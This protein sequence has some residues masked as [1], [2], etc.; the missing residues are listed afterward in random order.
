MTLEEVLEL[1]SCSCRRVYVAE[2]CCCL[3]AGFKCAEMCSLACSNMA[4]DDNDVD[5]SDSDGDD[6]NDDED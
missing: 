3:N 5:T 4:S 1:L 6:N 2:T